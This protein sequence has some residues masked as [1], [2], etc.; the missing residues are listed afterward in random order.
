MGLVLHQARRALATRNAGPHTVGR[1]L[2]QGDV[3][4][5]AGAGT[6]RAALIE[7]E[8]AV[9][10]AAHHCRQRGSSVTGAP[11]ALPQSPCSP[12]WPSLYLPYPDLSPLCHPLP[13]LTLGTAP[14]PQ[15]VGPRQ[16][17]VTPAWRQWLA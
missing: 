8:A 17:G 12:L 1:Q 14:S 2:P 5:E 9:Q 4:V 6:G 16:A 11:P 3:L 13:Q 7:H 15:S 10:G